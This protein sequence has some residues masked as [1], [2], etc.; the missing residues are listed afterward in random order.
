[1]T[2]ETGIWKLGEN[3][4]I[5]TVTFHLTGRLVKVGEKELIL[6]NASWIPDDGR[7]AQAVATGEFAEVE[8]YPHDMEVIVGR[9][10]VIDACV[11]PKLPRTQK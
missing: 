1:M 5:R 3:Y 7:F 9:G 11:I 8:P 2:K 4:F 6:V 10:S